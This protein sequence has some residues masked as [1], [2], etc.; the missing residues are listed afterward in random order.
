VSIYQLA[1][2]ALQPLS[3]KIYHKFSNKVAVL[4][5]L[6]IFE[7]GSA[8]CGAATSSGM[9]IA[10]RAIAGIG[11]AGV[12]S[13]GL[14]ITAAAMPLA[15]RVARMGAMMG[16]AQ[17]GIAIGPL[18]GGAFTSYTTWRW[19]FYI[20]LPVGGLLAAGLL[21]IRVPDQCDKPAASS[22]FRK[23][24]G[25]LDLFGFTLIASATAQLLFALSWGGSEYAWNSALI[26]GLFCG[27]AGTALLWLV[28]DWY[29]GDEALIPLSMI[30]VRGVW[31]GALT[32]CLFM[33]NVF[34]ASF[35]LPMYFQAV[36]GASPMMSGVYVL[37]SILAQLVAVPPTGKLG[38]SLPS[39]LLPESFLTV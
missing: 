18:L 32:H 31:A 13:G 17:L 4:A 8:I 37:A 10:G 30:R 29:R 7:I 5:F 27:A 38:E 26:V 21:F 14:T 25:E 22:V 12:I 9:L 39:E 16:F 15:T 23:L 11:S 1:S 2:A 36:R 19:C 20:N 6:A 24:H 33:T 28:W 3:G 35:F 34:C